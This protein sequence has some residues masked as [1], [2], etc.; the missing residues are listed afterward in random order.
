MGGWIA[1]GS[2]LLVLLL[3]LLIPVGVLLTLKDGQLGLRLKIWLF[4]LDMLKKKPEKPKKK[5]KKARKTQKE[6]PKPEKKTGGLDFKSL[7]SEKGDLAELIDLVKAFISK[8]LRGLRVNK[9]YVDLTL[10]TGD[11]AKTAILYGQL[12]A[13]LGMTLPYLYKWLRIKRDRWNI[14]P[15]FAKDKHELALTLDVTLTIGRALAIGI[16]A[17]RMVLKYYWPRRNRKAAEQANPETPESTDNAK[18][19]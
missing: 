15:D 11:A 14:L 9:L 8:A 16:A 6:K 5:P 17:L 10:A 3:I 7:I 18:A 13:I 12:C 19:A 2:V 1:L 4:K